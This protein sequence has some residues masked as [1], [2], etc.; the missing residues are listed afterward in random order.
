M[1]PRE[2]IVAEKLHAFLSRP[3][4]NSR[5]KDLYDL[6]FHLPA[7]DHGE[8]RSAASKT[9]LARDSTLPAD[10]PEKFRSLRT[11][12]LRRGWP[13]ATAGLTDAGSFEE[14]FARVLSLLREAFQ[15]SD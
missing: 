3:L 10:V 2:V 14:A 11:E 8:L 5:S 12:N 4:D 13:A 7:C 1:Y 9:F 15:V 6:A